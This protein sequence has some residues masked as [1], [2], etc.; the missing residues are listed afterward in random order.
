MRMVLKP[1]QGLEKRFK[2]LKFNRLP[3]LL[4]G[5]LRPCRDNWMPVKA[6]KHLR[7]YNPCLVQG[8]GRQV[9]EALKAEFPERSLTHTT[10]YSY[11]TYCL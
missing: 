9:K 1:I 11:K 6:R 8:K 10:V 3:I 2:K 4:F 5:Q 7:T